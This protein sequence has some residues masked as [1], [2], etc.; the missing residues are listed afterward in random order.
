MNTPDPRRDA[1]SYHRNIGPIT[2]VLKGILADRPGHALEVGSGSGQH[3]TSFAKSFPQLTW[4]PTEYDHDNIA[5]IDAWR[6]AEGTTN[7]QPA[8]QLDASKDNWALG[9]AGRPPA[10]LDAIFTANVIHISPWVV[11]A[12]IIQGAGRHLSSGGSLILYGPFMRADHPTA[13]SNTAFDEDLRSRNP[14]WGIR[15]LEDVSQLGREAGLAEPELTEMPAN[16]LIVH[17]LRQ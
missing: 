4:W 9:L 13:P 11:C 14:Q 17:F 16:N 3:V 5:S 2:E 1:P 15:N 10:E 6:T 7:I 12:G 8:I